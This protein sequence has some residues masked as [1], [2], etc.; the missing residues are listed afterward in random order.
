MRSLFNQSPLLVVALL[1]SLAG[2]EASEC[3]DDETKADG[4]CVAS[5]K[6][7]RGDTEEF[8]ATEDYES[9]KNVLIDS[10]NG[11][12][13]VKVSNRDDVH[14]TFK[15]FVARAHTLC[16]GEPVTSGDR[17]QAIDD[18]LAEQE[19]IFE[20]EDGHYLIQSQRHDSVASLGA[21][22]E[23]ELPS[24]FNG[25]LTIAQNNG[26]TD[27][28]EGLGEVAAVIVESQNGSC[29]IRTGT[30]SLIDINCKN[31]ET[32]VWIEGIA[33]GDGLRQ[34]Y[35]DSGQLGD[36]AVQ[37]PSTDDA[38]SVSA[39]SIDEDVAIEPASPS[40]CDV[41]GED[42]RS[43]TV[44]CNGATNEDPLYTVT[45]NEDLAEVLLAF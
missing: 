9:G 6:T 13:V 16:D 42:A 4:V 20:E 31:G 27:V 44:L 26:E 40:G 33:P 22:I 14:A 43:I 30:A 28:D 5:L 32:D 18:D 3:E 35:K 21:E 15:P 1:V 41:T 7:W 19:L 17:C 11:S 37:F 25:R 39:V 12:V 24:S 34:I 38:F 36:L 8:T 45:S 23:V 2:C 10:G 29:D